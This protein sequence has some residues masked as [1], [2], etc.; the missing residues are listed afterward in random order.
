MNLNEKINHGTLSE[1]PCNENDATIHTFKIFKYFQHA[2]A[3]SVEGCD[4]KLQL[5]LFFLMMQ[6]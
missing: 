5:Q 6:T 4:G 3:Y 1:N 2:A